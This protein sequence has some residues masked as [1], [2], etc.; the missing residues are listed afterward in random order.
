M[1]REV[2]QEAKK[3]ACLI[4]KGCQKYTSVS[5][6]LYSAAVIRV[7]ELSLIVVKQH[8]L[9]IP[10]FLN[11]PRYHRSLLP[12]RGSYFYTAKYAR[13]IPA[14]FPAWSAEEVIYRLDFAHNFPS[15][16]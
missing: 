2:T 10:G 11:S 9:Q 15:H 5:N 4:R 13:L 3:W 14:F 8:S 12:G 16:T 7:W 6:S 1:G